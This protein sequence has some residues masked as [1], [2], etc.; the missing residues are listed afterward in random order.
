[1]YYVV[2]G[3]QLDKIHSGSKHFYKTLGIKFLQ[4]PE[5]LSQNGP[6]KGPS[7][8]YV[9]SEEEGG[10]KLPILLS[11]KTTEGA[12]NRRFLDDIVYGP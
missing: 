6:H 8:N 10:Q 2:Y 4:L 11:K 1:M 9:V 12:K 5:F 7:I 3:Q